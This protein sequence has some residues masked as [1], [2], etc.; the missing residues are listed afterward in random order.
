MNGEARDYECGGLRI[1]SAVPLPYGVA[2][3][4]PAP[5]VEVR[6]G[7]V[8]S[9]RVLAPGAAAGFS[10][11]GDSLCLTIRD[12]GT[13]RARAGRE[14]VIDALPGT[15]A[16]DLQV[17]LAGSVLGAILHQRGVFPLHAS[18]V[19]VGGGAVAF[20]AGS[21]RG[22]STMAAFLTRR[23]YRL[24][25]DDVCVLNTER[26]GCVTVWPGAARLKLGRD[27]LG[28]LSA[29]VEGLERAGGTRDKYQVPVA[30]GAMAPALPLR[31][32]Y[33]LSDGDGPPRTERLAGL[34]ALDALAGQTYCAEFVP[35]M[36]LEKTWFYE[37]ARVA[38]AIEIKRLIRPRGFQHMDAVLD[39]LEAEWR[40]S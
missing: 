15:G 23:G 2:V 28:A 12:V 19:E 10:V 40:G 3:A 38:R 30:A 14:I 31:S 20:A 1:R 29:Q 24:V 11:E 4:G 9:P 22:K 16:M 35:A 27:G 33:I 13:F 25:T 21:G 5:D 8:E 6:F 36:R 34:D 18:A 26:A 7:R 39:M 37:V 17:Y 32:V